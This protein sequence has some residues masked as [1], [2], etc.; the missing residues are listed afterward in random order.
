MISANPYPTSAYFHEDDLFGLRVRSDAGDA[1]DLAIDLPIG[2][3]AVDVSPT[4]GAFW[5]HGRRFFGESLGECLRPF[6]PMDEDDEA[7]LRIS[8]VADLDEDVSAYFLADGDG[9][10]GLV[11]GAGRPL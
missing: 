6:W 5:L 10:L 9:W 11:D 1:H 7:A 4:D 3:Y 2:D 8:I